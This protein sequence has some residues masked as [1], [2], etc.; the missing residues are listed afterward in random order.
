[1]LWNLQRMSLLLAGFALRR[2]SSSI[3]QPSNSGFEIIFPNDL[4]GECLLV[5]IRRAPY[6]LT[7]IPT[8]AHRVNRQKPYFFS[9]APYL[10]RRPPLPAR[11]YTNHW[12]IQTITYIRLH[13]GI[14]FLKQSRSPHK[15]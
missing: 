8:K 14:C 12:L 11:H 7:I 10:K 1:M 3:P 15:V 13:W 4:L 6:N 5:I 2:V 9:I